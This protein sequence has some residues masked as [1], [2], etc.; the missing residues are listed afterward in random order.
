[1]SKRKLKPSVKNG[2]MLIHAGITLVLLATVVNANENDRTAME[3]IEFQ[4]NQID[5]LRND[6]EELKTLPKEEDVPTV[7][8]VSFTSYW[9][10]DP[11]GSGT[12]TGS[13][14]STSDFQI[15]EMG[16]YTYDGKV[17]IATA[18]WECVN[19]RYGAC[20]E[21]TEVPEGYHIMSYGDEVKIN[22]LGK[23]Y[24]AIVADTCGA[25]FWQEDYQR[26][27]IFVAAPEYGVGKTKG[28]IEY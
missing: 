11:T 8:E 4:A 19:S 14:L 27:D 3:I 18:T 10:G 20:A 15:N 9:N 5:E 2:L 12:T 28:Y 13:G 1:M 21:Y 24:N 7:Q 25:S 26:V 17:V 22:L 6:I 16:W 23:S